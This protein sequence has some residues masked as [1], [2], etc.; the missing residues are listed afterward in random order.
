MTSYT[1]KVLYALNKTDTFYLLGKTVRGVSD[2]TAEKICKKR[3]IT[4]R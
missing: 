3:K 4:R 2:G 1:K